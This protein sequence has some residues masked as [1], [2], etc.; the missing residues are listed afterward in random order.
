[1]QAAHGLRTTGGGGAG[2]EEEEGDGDG[3]VDERVMIESLPSISNESE[4]RNEEGE[5]IWS[6]R[7]KN[8]DINREKKREERKGDEMKKF[9]NYG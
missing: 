4:Q 7:G 6:F 9:E 8:R 3:G 2:E 5:M 1:M